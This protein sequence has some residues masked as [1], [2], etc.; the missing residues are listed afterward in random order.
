[1]AEV[2]LNT[3]EIKQALHHDAEFFIQFFLH[4]E[5][6]FPVPEFHKEIFYEMTDAEVDRLCLAIP[7]AHAK[8]TLAKLAAVWYFAF[9]PWRFIVYLSNTVSVAIPAVNDIVAF[10]ESPNFQAVFGPIEWIIKRDGTGL[11]KFNFMG[12]TCILKAFGSDQQ[13]RGINVD[14]ERPQLAIVD[15]LEDNKNIANEN[16]FMQLKRNFFGPFLKALNPRNYGS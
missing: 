9:S 13:V 16:L 11:Y 12:K 4:E 2:Q 10:M 14:N 5:L 15:D 7:R 1:M 8:T 3:F 6:E